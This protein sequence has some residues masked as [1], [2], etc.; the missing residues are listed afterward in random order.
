MLAPNKNRKKRKM[1]VC[2]VLM[3]FCYY[4]FCP[5]GAEPAGFWF[6]VCCVN[7]LPEQVGC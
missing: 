7:P 4:L 2:M 1:G 5:G 3:V 6:S